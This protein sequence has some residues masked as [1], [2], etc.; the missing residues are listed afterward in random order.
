MSVK[1]FQCY[2]DVTKVTTHSLYAISKKCNNV[3]AHPLAQ[4]REKYVQKMLN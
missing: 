1:F 4:N 2:I 3:T